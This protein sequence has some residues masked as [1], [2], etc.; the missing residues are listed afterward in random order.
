MGTWDDSPAGSGLRS[1]DWELGMV[2]RASVRL[3]AAL[4]WPHA[5][6]NEPI[7]RPDVEVQR[8]REEEAGERS[9]EAVPSPSRFQTCSIRSHPLPP[10]QRKRQEWAPHKQ[11]SLLT[12]VWG[13]CKGLNGSELKQGSPPPSMLET[14][15][16]QLG[17]RA[18]K[19]L[20]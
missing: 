3:T 13:P 2:S 16:P 17:P 12:H 14:T 7:A 5:A 20:T 19:S 11:P 4:P 8:Q 18:G 1:Q 6:E 9:Q 15:V 10:P